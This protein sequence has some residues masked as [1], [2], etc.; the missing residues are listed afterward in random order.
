MDGPSLVSELFGSARI[1][2]RPRRSSILSFSM[3]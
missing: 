2:N 3:I 1:S